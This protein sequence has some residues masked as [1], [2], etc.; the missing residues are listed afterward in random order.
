M[1]QNRAAAVSK[2]RW[3]YRAIEPSDILLDSED[4]PGSVAY[5]KLYAGGDYVRIEDTFYKWVG[6]HYEPQD[7]RAEKTR[8]REV[9]NRCIRQTEKATTRPWR[10]ASK[11]CDAY[12]WALMSV[13]FVPSDVVNPPGH[14]N[15]TNGVF[16][17]DYSDGLPKPELLPHS[18]EMVF[19]YAPQVAYHPEADPTHANRLLA[20][21][22]DNGR[23]AVLRVLASAIDIAAIRAAWGRDSRILF[24]AGSGANGKDAIR[25]A[26]VHIF[27]NCGVTSATIGDFVDY[28]QGRKFSLAP[29]ISSRINWASENNTRVNI[30]ELNPLKHFVTGEELQSE[31]K[32][33]DPIPF[34]P[35][36]ICIFN[37]NDTVI[38]LTAKKEASA[39]RYAIVFFR[40]T[41]VSHPKNPDQLKADPRFKY[42]VQ[43]VKAHVCPALLNI[44]VAEFQNLFRE[45]VDYSALDAELKRNLLEANHLARFCHDCN[46]IEDPESSIETGMVWERLRTWYQSEGILTIS[47]DGRETWEGDIREGDKWLRGA[48]QLTRKLRDLYPGM[49]L[50]RTGS[51][52]LISG[53]RFASDAEMA[54]R[55][56]NAA[57]EYQTALKL[58]GAAAIEKAWSHL[59]R[60]KQELIAQWI[61]PEEV[62]GQ[63]AI[64]LDAIS[65]GNTEAVAYFSEMTPLRKAAI[66]ARLSE[67][68]RRQATEFIKR[69]N[70]G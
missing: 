11:I 2:L 24:F 48:Q 53:L 59:P 15:L 5:D 69:A 8:I 16:H 54:L 30:D 55:A 6:T 25:E 1:A 44:L 47:H 68:D 17:F 61:E 3:V 35:K 41:F 51:A 34:I 62:S 66:W 45:G 9:L 31:R 70:S 14:I 37:T 21:L 29:L 46:L 40:K 38:N 13:R 52:R 67:A 32:F 36:A 49:E 27:G 56:V 58:Y 50:K 23:T 43:W 63:V 18:P 19:T 12:Q 20:A 22:P 65:G 57:E 60:A 39:G 4:S 10:S 64:L 26:F 7:E 33:A 42:D 28:H